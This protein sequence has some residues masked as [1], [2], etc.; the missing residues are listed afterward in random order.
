MVESEEDRQG[1]AAGRSNP[2]FGRV[3]VVKFPLMATSLLRTCLLVFICAAAYAD[4]VDYRWQIQDLSKLPDPEVIAAVSDDQGTKW[5]ATKKGLARLNQLGDWQTFTAE[6]TGKGLISNAITALAIGENRE[7]W[8]ATEEGVSWFAN[9]SWR[10]FT[11]ENTSGGLPDNFVTSMAIGKEERWFGTKNG[12]ALLR[13]SAWTPYGPDRISG[14]QWDAPY[15]REYFRCVR[16]DGVLVWL[17]RGERPGARVEGPGVG[18]GGERRPGTGD[19]RAGSGGRGAGAGS[20]DRGPGSGERGAGGETTLRC[21]HG[22]GAR[23][24]R[25]VAVLRPGFRRRRDPSSST[26][27]LAS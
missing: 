13:G 1:V 27:A 23:E 6:T 15:A 26:I 9:G 4:E 14:G 3:F 22:G 21:T 7:L 10:A 5:F 19:R 24:R 2:E 12:F 17:F 20:G 16:E 25:R 11:K 8:V 18:T